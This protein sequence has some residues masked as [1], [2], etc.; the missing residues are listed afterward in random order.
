MNEAY[1]SYED[2]ATHAPKAI[3]CCECLGPIP[4]KASYWMLVCSDPGETPAVFST[5]EACHAQRLE[6]C[7]EFF[8][9]TNLLSDLEALRSALP[10]DSA[11]PWA[12]LTNAVSLLRQRIGGANPKPLPTYTPTPLRG[13]RAVYGGFLPNAGA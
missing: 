3:R 9:P 13:V 4:K 10:Y 11:R 8:T 5:C 6:F 7:T 1:L 2:I 12:L